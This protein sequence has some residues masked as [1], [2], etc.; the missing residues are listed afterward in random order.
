MV[1]SCLLKYFDEKKKERR[2][3]VRGRRRRRLKQLLGDIKRK[4]DTGN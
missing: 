2:R 1:I 3:K 4:E